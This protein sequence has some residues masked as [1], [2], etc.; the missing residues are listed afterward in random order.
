MLC[1]LFE[2]SLY[3]SLLILIIDLFRM[4]VLATIP[5]IASWI[6]IFFASN[7]VIVFVFVNFR[8]HR[9]LSLSL[10]IVVVIVY[11]CCHCLSLLSLSIVVV[12]SSVSLIIILTFI[13]NVFF[14][15][16]STS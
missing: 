3:N 1:K 14:N 4:L 8:C 2:K 13:V 10:S 15:I 9:Q 12:S 5:N 7:Q 16:F 6:I 11:R